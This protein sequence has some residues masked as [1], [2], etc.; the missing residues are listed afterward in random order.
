MAD[1]LSTA[2]FAIAKVNKGT[3]TKEAAEILR[4]ELTAKSNAQ[5]LV[6]QRADKKCAY[7][8]VRVG[9]SW[10]GNDFLVETN[11]TSKNGLDVSL[12]QWH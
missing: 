5:W 8:V 6:Q 9:G 2:R 10:S 3:S 7:A 4:R 11:K 1:L 12:Y